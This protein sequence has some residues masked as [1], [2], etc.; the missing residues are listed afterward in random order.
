MDTDYPRRE[1]ERG[2]ADTNKLSPTTYWQ[3]YCHCHNTRFAQTDS[4]SLV[5]QAPGVK[6]IAK[7]IDC[8]TRQA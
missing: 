1:L 3:K 4:F 7:A 8:L 2:R 6:K 5:H